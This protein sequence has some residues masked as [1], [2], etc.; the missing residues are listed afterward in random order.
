MLPPPPALATDSVIT[1]C[2]TYGHNWCIGA[3][4]LGIG[5][6]VGLTATGRRINFHDQ[7]YTCCGGHEVFQLQFA[8]DTTK[9]VGVASGFYFTTVRYCSSGNSANVNWALVSGGSDGSV[10]FYSNTYD[11]YLASDNLMDG[12]LY[13]YPLPCNGCYA[14][15][16]I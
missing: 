16:N 13:V 15:W 5:D 12:A 2:N 14:K 6:G 10:L 1:I 8:A 11:E 4:T 9:C 7:G 3:P